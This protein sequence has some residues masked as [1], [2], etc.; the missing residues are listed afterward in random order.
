MNP[1]YPHDYYNSNY[2]TISRHTMI[3]METL[4]TTM[5][6]MILIIHT[7]I[8]RHTMIIMGTLITTMINMI[9]TILLDLGLL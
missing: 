5:I 1:D 9:L 3:I 4:I 8:S 6:T 2:T 7:T